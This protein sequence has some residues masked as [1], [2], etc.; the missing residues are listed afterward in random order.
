MR[1]VGDS[2]KFEYRSEVDSVS[3]A[4][5]E[6]LSKNPGDRKAEDVKLM[7]DKLEKLY[8]DW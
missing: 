4:L 7:I 1:L 6:W 5:Q 2:V 3:V 8:R